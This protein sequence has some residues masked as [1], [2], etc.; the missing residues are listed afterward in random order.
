MIFNKKRIL[1]IG[2]SGSG[3]STFSKLLGEK[4]NIE[5][6]H[7]DRYFWKPGWIA[8][9][10]NEW[11][12]IL[13]E[14]INKDEWI[15]DGNFTG[16]LKYRAE[17]SDLIY[18]FDYSPLFCVYRIYK[19]ILRTKLGVEAR[20]DITEGCPEK[21]YDRE[22]VN[23][24]RNFNRITRPRIYSSLEEINYDKKNIIKFRNRTEFRD[25]LKSLNL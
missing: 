23:F 11:Y 19:R 25:Y 18:F 2:N 22:F 8:C 21:W 3:K 24:V 15:I 4:L 16:T 5:V 17:R 1:I 13:K 12:E 9:E 14:L 7:L 6:F 10:E 20:Y